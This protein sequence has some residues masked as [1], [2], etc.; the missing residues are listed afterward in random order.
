MKRLLLFCFLGL[1]FTACGN[2]QQKNKTNYPDPEAMQALEQRMKEKSPEQKPAQSTTSKEEQL[3]RLAS[4]PNKT[5]K[6]QPEP[7]EEKN[8]K[9]LKRSDGWTYGKCSFWGSRPSTSISVG[10]VIIYYD[11]TYPKQTSLSGGVAIYESDGNLW[12]IYRTRED[13]SKYKFRCTGVLQ[14]QNN[15]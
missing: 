13:L 7:E 3:K 12:V 14:E 1:L 2:N 6:K 4:A 8:P 11:G 5:E 15:F 9:T 10:T